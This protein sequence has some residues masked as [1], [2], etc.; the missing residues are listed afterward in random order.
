MIHFKHAFNHIDE[1][2]LDEVGRNEPNVIKIL[3]IAM[4]VCFNSARADELGG[5]QSAHI[6]YYF[7]GVRFKDWQKNYTPNVGRPTEYAL[8]YTARTKANIA[9]GA[10]TIK[11]IREYTIAYAI[12]NSEFVKAMIEEEPSL[13]KYLETGVPN[14]N[15]MAE[16]LHEI[17]DECVRYAK[18]YWKNEVNDAL[19]VPQTKLPFFGD[20]LKSSPYGPGQKIRRLTG[21][22][23]PVEP[24][25]YNAGILTYKVLPKNIKDYY[26][27]RNKVMDMQA[28]EY[29]GVNEFGEKVMHRIGR[30]TSTDEHIIRCADG[31]IIGGIYGPGKYPQTFVDELK[32][33]GLIDKVDTLSIPTSQ[34][35]FRAGFVRKE[36]EKAFGA[37]GEGPKKRPSTGSTHTSTAKDAGGVNATIAF[38]D[39]SFTRGS[40][41]TNAFVIQYNGNHRSKAEI[42]ID[43]QNQSAE[44]TNIDQATLDKI[45]SRLKD[46]DIEFDIM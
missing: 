12:D 21:T 42:D 34:A 22:D 18:V 2:R 9:H 29:P 33:N 1:A 8:F 15:K 36:M 19:I 28:V 44:I 26:K 11:D 27:F 37:S 23:E 13:R 14:L 4:Q 46:K 20:I 5:Q 38:K 24:S 16:A 10:S 39:D 25:E 43:D 41:M 30:G 3:K 7:D 6:G 40:K 31:S 32:R 17:A 35:G 45:S